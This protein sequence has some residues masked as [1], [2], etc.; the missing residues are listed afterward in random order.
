MKKIIDLKLI[1]CLLLLDLTFPQN[2]WSQ[3]FCEPPVDWELLEKNVHPTGQSIVTA[4]TISQTQLTIPS[5]WW[6]R[7]QFD[8]FGGKLITN[9]LAYAEKKRIDLIVNR[10]LWSLMDYIDHYRLVNN[11][12][13][14]A[15]QYGYNLRVF[16][17]KK[18]CLAVYYYDSSVS[19]PRWQLKFSAY[20]QRGLGL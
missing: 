7:Q 15:R 2:T 12:G 17:Q 4:D 1:F 8:P 20:S 6:V 16:N 9:W 18:I 13:T 5:L 19:P 3:A 10:Q 14:V 11:F